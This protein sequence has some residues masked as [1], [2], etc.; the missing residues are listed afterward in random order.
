MAAARWTLIP[1]KTDVSSRKG[2]REVAA[3]FA[4]ARRLNP[5]LAVLGVVLFGVNRSATRIEAEARAAIEAELGDVAPVFRSTIRHVEA[6]AYDVRERGQLVHELE[7]SALNAP[8]WFERIRSGGAHAHAPLAS[9]AG[10]LAGDYQ[11]M[12]EEIFV[13]LTA[14]EDLEGAHA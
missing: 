1:T 9:S 5:E 10:A 12:A 4:V 3:R 11:S 13:H 2:L 8:K 14:V 6:S 7:Q